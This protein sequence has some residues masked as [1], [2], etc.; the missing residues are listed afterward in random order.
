MLVSGN[1]C[2]WIVLNAPINIECLRAAAIEV[3][4]V[5]PVLNSIQVKKGFRYF[6]KELDDPISVDIRYEK[7]SEQFAARLHAHLVRNI[8]R[9]PLPLTR[10]RPW[11][12]HVTDSPDGRTYL[13]IITTHVFTDGRSANIVARDL[14]AAYSALA[15]QQDCQLQPIRGSRDPFELFAGHLPSIERKRLRRAGFKAIL[16]DALTRC[17][18]LKTDV[19]RRGETAVHF[20]DYGIAMWDE[21]KRVS[22]HMD[23]SVHPFILASVLRIIE[24]LNDR[25]GVRSPVVRI[26]DNF[27]LRRFAADRATIDNLYDVFAVPYTLDFS[28]RGDDVSLVTQIRKQM[29]Q[30]K[31]GEILRELYRYQIYHRAGFFSDQKKMAT[32]LVSRL[33][34]R[35]NVVCT[36]IGPVP[37]DFAAFGTAQVE[38]Y[39]S[40]AQLFP[41]GDLM[42]LFSTYRGRLRLVLLHDDRRVSHEL[43]EEIGERLFAS[44]LSRVIDSFAKAQGCATADTIHHFAG[45]V[46]AHATK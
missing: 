32:R 23:M 38:D 5:H 29:D 28:L 6:W 17:V 27:S 8:H 14:A 41:P 24:Q 1:S 13:Q 26:V 7:V 10:E 25:R 31:R 33:V 37:E 45:R 22:R 46:I 9:E 20:F 40:F 4:R 42:F 19:S 12:I 18:G 34:V 44:N 43:A 39:Y 30:M 21:V 11:R 16:T 15:S 35:T 36:N 2:E 3:V